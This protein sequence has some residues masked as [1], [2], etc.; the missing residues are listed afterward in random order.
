MRSFIQAILNAVA[1][2]VSGCIIGAGG[3]LMLAMGIG[4]Y[5]GGIWLCMIGLDW[6][7]HAVVQD[8]VIA[9]SVITSLLLVLCAWVPV[10]G[11]AVAFFGTMGALAFVGGIAE[12]VR[13][14]IT[15]D[16]A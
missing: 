14:M 1:F 9:Y 13:N 15:R 5:G 6:A 4:I 2:V 10:V 12:A 3:I 7:G 11:P 8:P 16:N